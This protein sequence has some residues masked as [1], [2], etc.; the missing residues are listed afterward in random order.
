M[1]TPS[2]LEPALQARLLQCYSLPSPITSTSPPVWSEDHRLAFI[3]RKG[4]YV[5]E[6]LPDA[7]KTTQKLSFEKTFVENPSQPNPWQLKAVLPDDVL[8][9]LEGKTRA[10][11]MMDRVMAPQSAG[12]ELIY[13][14]TNMVGW[15]PR[16]IKCWKSGNS[17]HPPPSSCLLL[18]ATADFW[19][20]LHVQEGRQWRTH[21]DLSELLWNYLDSIGGEEEGMEEEEEQEVSTIL[22]KHKKLAYRLATASH[23]WTKSGLLVTGQMGGQLVTYSMEG[24]RILDLTDTPLASIFCLACV[25]M[26]G[27]ELVVAGGGCGKVAALSWEEGRW[28]E[29]GE[30]WGEEDHLVLTRVAQLRDCLVLGKGGFC[31]VVNVNIK[32]ESGETE[33]SGVRTLHCGITKIIGLQVLG[34]KVLIGNQKGPV[35]VWNLEKGGEGKVDLE[36][37]FKHY[38]T[39]GIVASPNKS[40]FVTIQSIDAFND[41]LIMREPGR[42]VFWTLEDVASL[43]ASFAGGR[44]G[45][46]MLEVVRC[47]RISEKL[48]IPLDFQCPGEEEVLQCRL[49]W[50]KL[51][52]MTAFKKAD[53]GVSELAQQCEVAIRCAEAARILEDASSDSQSKDASASFILAFSSDPALKARAASRTIFNWQCKLCPSSLSSPFTTTVSSITCVQNHSWPRCLFTQRPVMTPE[54]LVCRWCGSP[55]SLSTAPRPCPLCQGPLAPSP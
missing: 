1:P 49:D 4:V 24:A 51:Q 44:F 30:V 10:G 47:L 21:I 46:D 23:C 48:E 13:R 35:K 20:R 15:T 29:E 33:F 42:L 5:F 50:W 3:T 34:G 52:N 55:A 28:K 41:H 7:G 27:K 26:G 54:P 53:F 40:L 45:P 39:Y 11:V 37:D 31:L 18:T 19:L 8:W 38:M 2:S 22:E 12:A 36:A 25:N 14:Q 6:L 9:R 43:E 16:G 17:T 32:A